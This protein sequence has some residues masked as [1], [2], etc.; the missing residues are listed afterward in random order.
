MNR[1]LRLAGW[2]LAVA[3]ALA[4]A[5]AIQLATLPGEAFA[6]TAKSK[7]KPKP[8]IEK[9]QAPAA[10]VPPETAP[11]AQPSP[12]PLPPERVEA[13]VSTRTIAITSGYSGSEILIFGAIEFSRQPSAESGFYDVVVVVEGAPEPLD[14][15]QKGRVAGLWVNTKS[16]SFNAVP[17]YY[18]VAST[19]PIEEFAD[20]SVL[21]ENGIGLEAV[22]M[23]AAADSAVRVSSED[24]IGYKEAVTRLKAQQGLFKRDDYGVVFTGRSL[25]RSKI[26]LPATVPVGPLTARVYL[27]HEGTLLSRYQSRVV[28]ER[29]GIER[30]LYAFAFERPFLYGIVAVL[31]ALM[32]GLIAS[33]LFHRRS[34]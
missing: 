5:Q 1:S 25:F 22:R 26:D 34:A 29:E 16:F 15:R 19:R 20:T 23:A 13:D 30:W 2:V 18:A 24:L 3:V 33:A 11:A 6:Q 12:V 21:E 9:P 8:A 31:L 14:V 10:A 17:S 28:L 32:T 27:F 7:K 4:G